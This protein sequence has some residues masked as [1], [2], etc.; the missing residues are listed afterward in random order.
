MFQIGPKV[1]RRRKLTKWK[2]VQVNF[3]SIS[4]DSDKA[5]RLYE[6]KLNKPP[7]LVKMCCGKVTN[8]V[9]TLAFL[10]ERVS[11]KSQSQSLN[12]TRILKYFKNM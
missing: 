2:V 3:L 11:T 6:E 7:C 10:D 9:Q 12:N 8:L 4:R 5:V 1:K